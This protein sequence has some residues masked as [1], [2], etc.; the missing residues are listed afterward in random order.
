MYAMAHGG[1][2]DTVRE[3]ALKVDSGWKVPCRTGES[4]LPQRRAT[5]KLYQSEALP[6]ELD[7]QPYL[8]VDVT[9]DTVLLVRMFADTVSSD[10]PADIVLLVC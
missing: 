4:N 1:C 5:P 10:V 7:P 2:T 3:S 9:A 8:D 6:I